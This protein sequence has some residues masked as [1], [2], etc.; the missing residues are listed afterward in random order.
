MKTSDVHKNSEENHHDNNTTPW[1]IT[2]DS[3]PLEQTQ[4][5]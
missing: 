5:Y 3:Q 4:K 2:G 1:K